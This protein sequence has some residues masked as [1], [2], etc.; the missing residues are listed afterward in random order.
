M[1]NNPTTTSRQP[2]PS[3]TGKATG[4]R[5]PLGNEGWGWVFFFF[6]L[7]W[8]WASWWMGDVMRIAYERS[9][10][11]A[12][13]TLMRW[14]WQKSFG[15]LWVIGRALLT[16]YRWPVVGGLFVAILLTGGSWIIGY[17]LHLP[18]RWRWTQYLPAFAWMMWTAYVG[19]NL[20]YYREPGRILAIPFL[21]VVVFG[22]WAGLSPL[23]SGHLTRHKSEHLQKTK[24][25]TPSLIGRA[26]SGALLLII[27]FAIPSF[28]LTLRHPYLRPLTKMQVQLMHNDYEGMSK[29]AHE[30]ADM[31]NRQM[32]GYY[33][34][35]LARTGHLADQLFD[36]KLDFDTV[37]AL[38]YNDKPNLCLNYH[39]I[40][41]DYHAGL[42]RAARHYAVE[43]LTMDGPSLYIMKMLVKI[44][45]LEGDWRLAR[46]YLHVIGK[47]P[48]EG[49]FIH[50]YE[51]M[52]GH[53]DLVTADPE[54]G[55]V[56]HCAPPNHTFEQM[57]EKPAFI[58]YY[59]LLKQFKDTEAATWSAVACLYAKRMEDFL[60]RCGKFMDTTPPRSIIEGL[61]LE[62]PKYPDIQDAFPQVEL[63]FDRFEL[64]LQEAQPYMEDRALGSE[65]LFDKYKGYYPYYYFFGN[66][67]ATR[68]P[69]D[70]EQGHNRAGVN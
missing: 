15:W 65:V 46:K 69:G 26:G 47:A 23:R 33:A 5:A 2:L 25:I 17:C 68:K 14:L 66:L 34:I 28:Y 24:V 67:K 3:L 11:A 8:L 52:V 41:C 55:A 13:A 10:F 60:K 18:R 20:Y 30:H 32:A 36:I 16:L 1:S 9:F 62:T 63:G 70:D 27:F 51:P 54:L 12:D 7:A 56:L 6:L 59:A 64:F 45:L 38:G 22:I 37:R 31:G 40:D 61:V 48:F 50:Q 44:S 39:I 49:E 53:P 29:T 57:A 4:R 42:Y 19:L 21:V 43:D 35:A 58:G